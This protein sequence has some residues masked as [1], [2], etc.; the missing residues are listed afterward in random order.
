MTCDIVVRGATLRAGSLWQPGAA[1]LRFVVAS[2]S[3]G[4]WHLCRIWLYRV[5]GAGGAGA[6]ARPAGGASGAVLGR[7][8]SDGVA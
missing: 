8:M 1:N 4:F 5:K 7:A 3:G 6:T 2:G